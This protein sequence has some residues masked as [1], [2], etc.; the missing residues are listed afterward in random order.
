LL[1]SKL[2]FFRDKLFAPRAL[3]PCALPAPLQAS[4]KGTGAEM[5]AKQVRKALDAIE[6]PKGIPTS[7]DLKIVA[8]RAAAVLEAASPEAV[9]RL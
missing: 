6:V 1:A 5:E 4:E 8:E 7:D 9:A 3:A 2:R